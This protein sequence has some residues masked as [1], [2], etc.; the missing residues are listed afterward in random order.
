MA[1]VSL[2]GP[3][4]AVANVFPVAAPASRI[5]LPCLSA[6]LCLS[7]DLRLSADLNLSA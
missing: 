4:L 1:E 2:V 7:E 3:Y 6:D 5:S